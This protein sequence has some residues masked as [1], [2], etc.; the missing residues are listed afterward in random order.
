MK[1]KRRCI[2]SLTLGKEKVQILKTRKIKKKKYIFE[3]R[4]VVYVFNHS[5]Q[6]ADP[7]RCV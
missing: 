4:V 7:G 1:I 3:P 5:T 2:D 6:E